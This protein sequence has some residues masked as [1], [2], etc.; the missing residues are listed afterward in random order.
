M[1]AGGSER[2]RAG[3]RHRED[4]LSTDSKMEMTVQRVDANSITNRKIDTKPAESREINKPQEG[5]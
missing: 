5:F 4:T 2:K 1:E 3:Q